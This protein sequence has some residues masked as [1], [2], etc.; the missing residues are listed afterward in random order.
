MYLVVCTRPDLSMVVSALSWYYHNPQPEHWEVGKRVLRYLKGSA[1]EGLSYSLGEDVAVWGYS[2][3]SYGSDEESKRGRSGY[4]FMSAGATVSL[5]SK[6]QDVVALCSTEAE[7][8]AIS[9]ALQEG[10]Y[11]RML[12]VEMG[13]EPDM[14]GTL[15]L[16]DNQSAFKL[17]KN[18]VF[19][20]RSK[21]I[22]I[23]FY[24]IRERVEREEFCLEFVRTM[25]MAA[26]QL[27]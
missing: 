13:V 22:T 7:Y 2:D 9:H 17:A 19:H 20:K 5:G 15:L 6:L 23:R 4:V 1:E 10:L 12:Q 16:L 3:A 11:L 26:D 24:L 14:G 8:M 18:P 25:A 21:H 27:T